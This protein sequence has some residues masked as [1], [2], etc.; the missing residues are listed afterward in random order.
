MSRG[1]RF[2]CCL[3]ALS[4][5]PALRAQTAADSANIVLEAAR[6]LAR[7]GHRDAARRLFGLIRERWAATSAAQAA[8]SLLATLAPAERRGIGSLG[9]TGYIL[10]H[11]LYGGFLGAA[12]PAAFG[13]N[14]TE[15]Y[16][17]GLLIGAP[18]GFFGSRAFARAHITMPGQAGVASFATAWGTWQGLAVQ[19]ML[20]IG[21]EEICSTDLCFTD[22]SDTAPWAAM[23]VGGLAGLGTG[24]ALAA[25]EIR[26]GTS[27]LIS[28]SAFWGSWYGVS[29]GRVFGAEDNTLIGTTL[30]A[31]NAALLA[32]IPAAKAWR[33]GSARVRL[34]TAAGIAG[35][36][37]GIGI[38][39]IASID[40]ER[41]SWAIPAATS[42]LGL[43][44]GALATANRRD[45][46]EGEAA[47][48]ALLTVRERARLGVPLPFPAA[49]PTEEPGRRR[50]R[51][52]LRFLLL[53][54]E[55]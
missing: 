23:V 11:T 43:L 49:I 39:L 42:A 48:A 22:E 30:I 27:T 51:P 1:L 28:H 35:G 18:L 46:D 32:A 10:F 53:D 12:I 13:A 15:P 50:F 19:Q 44:A 34:T 16:G 3:G 55:F 37:A 54:A 41:S 8:E 31:G 7:E 29:L 14:G 6:T 24:L 47:G 52:G 33:P 21:D 45:A 2:V 4:G 20:D 17:A 36:L 9:R 38:D 40:D 5:A 25:R 26:A